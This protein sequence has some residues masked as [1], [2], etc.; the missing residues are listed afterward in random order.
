[1]IGVGAARRKH[2][3]GGA[4][5]LGDPRQG[6]QISRILNAIEVEPDLAPAGMDPGEVRP[7]QAAASDQAARRV[8]VGQRI[9]NRPRREE[10]RAG[11]PGQDLLSGGAGEELFGGQH[12]LQPETRR[13]G[14]ENEV[15]TLEDRLGPLRS[16]YSAES[17]DSLVARA[18]DHGTRS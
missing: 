14:L 18:L 16:P 11:E 7:R 2:Q 17:F 4:E 6:A 10:R 9:E 1:M 8:G 3:T 15:R 13:Q 5:P 12:R